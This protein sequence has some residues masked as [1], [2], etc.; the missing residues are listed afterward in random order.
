MADWS[1][2]AKFAGMLGSAGDGEV[3]AAARMIDRELK[4]QG[5]SWADFVQRLQASNGGGAPLQGWNEA[6]K[7]WNARMREEEERQRQRTW[8]QRTW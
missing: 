6:N 7:D 2:I 5:L 4:A 3:V 1:R 8:G